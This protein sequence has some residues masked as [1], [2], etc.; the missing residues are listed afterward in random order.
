MLIVWFLAL[1]FGALFTLTASWL[2]MGSLNISSASLFSVGS[3]SI[4]GWRMF[5]FICCT[6][7]FVAAAI[8]AGMS[9]TPAFLFSVSG[10]YVLQE[11]INHSCS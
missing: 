4:A 5:L 2:T 7:A 3:D 8:T 11:V 1:D 10:V 9:E 6:V